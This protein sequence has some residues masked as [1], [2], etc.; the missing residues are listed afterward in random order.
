MAS[1]LLMSLHAGLNSGIGSTDK[2]PLRLNQGI[3]VIL[4]R[5]LRCLLRLSIYHTLHVHVL[6][7]SSLISG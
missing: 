7:I 6:L 3:C 2:G 5:T 4:Y 1:T